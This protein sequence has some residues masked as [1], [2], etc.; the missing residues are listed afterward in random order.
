M[1]ERPGCHLDYDD[2]CVIE[3]GIEAGLSASAIARRLEVSPSTVTREVKANRHGRPSRAKA[4]R[5]ARK[6]ANYDGCRRF[7]DVCGSCSQ[8]GRLFFTREFFRNS[9][10]ICFG[11]NGIGK[12]AVPLPP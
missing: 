6:C 1:P 5:P 10:V 7:R 9:R 8:E 12:G 4:V 11:F 2:R 3:E